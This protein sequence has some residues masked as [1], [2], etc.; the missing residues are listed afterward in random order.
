MTASKSQS[1]PLGDAL[2]EL[3][4]SMLDAH[5]LVHRFVVERTAREIGRCADTGRLVIGYVA[6]PDYELDLRTQEVLDHV[7]HA[8]MWFYSEGDEYCKNPSTHSMHLLDAIEITGNYDVLAERAGITRSRAK[9]FVKNRVWP[10][11]T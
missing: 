4:R 7:E 3:D 6:N 10:W 8:T 1:L 11:T 5:E 2:L 9:T